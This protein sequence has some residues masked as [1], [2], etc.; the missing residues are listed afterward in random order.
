MP[1]FEQLIASPTAAFEEG[2]A[3]FRGH[4][5]LNSTLARLASD[6]DQNGIDYAVIGAVAL[7]QHGFADHL[8]QSVREKFRELQQAVA[9]PVGR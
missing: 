5:M 2:L 9:R 6:L 8:D 7:S 4:G 1:N 3:F